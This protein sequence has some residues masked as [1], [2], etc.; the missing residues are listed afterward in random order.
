M[1]DNTQ[2]PETE[3]TQDY[4]PTKPFT[5]QDAYEALIKESEKDDSKPELLEIES[6]AKEKPEDEILV[7]NEPENANDLLEGES[8][9]PNDDLEIEDKTLRELLDDETVPDN[10]RKR[11]REMEKGVKKVLNE[12][13]AEKEEAKA[14]KEHYKG[15]EGALANPEY[16][17][18]AIKQLVEATAQAT[19]LS[20]NQL[21]A[22]LGVSHSQTLSEVEQIP[23]VSNDFDNYRDYGFESKIEMKLAAELQAVKQQN[24][25]V[26]KFVQQQKAMAMA[27]E[28]QKQTSTWI[29]N[30]SEKIID[31]ID[32]D[33]DGLKLDKSQ[34]VEALNG[35]QPKTMDEVVKIV[36]KHHVDLFIEHAAKSSIPKAPKKEILTGN[37]PAG[38]AIG[39]GPKFSG[40][41]KSTQDAYDFV[42]SQYSKD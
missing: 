27:L 4:I 13:K 42:C 20:V 11:A 19:N 21:V 17:P 40:I 7:S 38:K 9:K 41:D 18:H 37:K 16:A 1:A 23:V 31:K 2:R 5:A 12:L 3:S 10:I 32:R 30:N 25:E 39:S 28:Q 35:E 26:A 33:F 14:V 6:E 8:P 34:I 24:V 22:L 15:W 36:K 29:N